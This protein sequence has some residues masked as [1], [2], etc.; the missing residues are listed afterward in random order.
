MIDTRRPVAARSAALGLAS[1]LLAPASAR[2]QKLDLGNPDDALKAQRKLFCTLKDGEA[3]IF[4][5]YGN[6]YS[7]VPGERDR[8]LFAYQAMNIRQ[9]K[10]VSEAGKGYGYRQVSR[11]VLFYQDPK[12]GEILRTWKNPWTGEDNDV[13]HV[14][15]DPV[16]QPPTFAQGPRGPFKFGA[17][18]K[19]GWGTLGIEVP[20]FYINVMGGDYQEYVGGTYQAIEMFGFFFREDELLGPSDSAPVNVSWARVSQWLPWMRMGSRLGYLMVSGYGGKVAGW[21]SLPESLRKEIEANYPEYRT[22]PP[23][24]DARPNET[25]WTV[26]KKWIDAK[27]KAVATPPKTN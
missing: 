9:T 18:F 8:Q 20:L 26:F 4:Y 15:N 14:A 2:A 24:D 3:K 6:V 23:L 11:E 22:P 19:D 13:V 16:N 17:V 5:F 7:R 12:T 1:L 27:R 25:S 10:T 21:E